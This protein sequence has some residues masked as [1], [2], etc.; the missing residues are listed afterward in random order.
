[1]MKKLIHRINKAANKMSMQ[2][3]NIYSITVI[4]DKLHA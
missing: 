3:D 2:Q 4:L 1:M